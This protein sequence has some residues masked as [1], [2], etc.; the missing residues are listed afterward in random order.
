MR[1]YIKDY[2]DAFKLC[3][4]AHARG[5]MTPF[6]LMFLHVLDSSMK[7][8]LEALEKRHKQLNYYARYSGLFIK[9]KND[10]TAGDL[11]YLLIQ[12]S[13]FADDGISTADLLSNL[14]VSKTTLSN[15]LAQ[16]PG[17]LLK[18]KRVGKGNYYQLDLNVLDQQ[19]Y[20]EKRGV[21]QG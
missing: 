18:V 4:D 15:K 20:A 8:L 10:K 12:A 6:L 17:G 19:I 2:Y 11:I 5:D 21:P 1:V 14:Q 9:S 7:Q 13:L 3:N 16:L